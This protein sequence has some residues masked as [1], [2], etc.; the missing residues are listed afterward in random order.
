MPKPQQNCGNCRFLDDTYTDEKPRCHRYPPQLQDKR[1]VSEDPLLR[2]L[3]AEPGWKF[4]EMD[5]SNWCGEWQPIL[6]SGSI[7]AYD[8]E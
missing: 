3:E 2:S 5:K 7:S 8:R 6:N 1:V 4:P